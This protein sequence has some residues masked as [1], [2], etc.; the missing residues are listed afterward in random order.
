MIPIGYSCVGFCLR[1]RNG[2]HIMIMTVIRIL[3]FDFDICYNDQ[4]SNG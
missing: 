3:D 1:T 4:T 2:F